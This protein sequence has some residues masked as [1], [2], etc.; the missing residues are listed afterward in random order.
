[1][2]ENISKL[3]FTEHKGVK[4]LGISYSFHLALGEW[5]YAGGS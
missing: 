4:A 5:L 3:Y 2:G 1:M